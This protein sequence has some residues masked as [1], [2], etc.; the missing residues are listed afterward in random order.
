MRGQLFRPQ[1]LNI[2]GAINRMVLSAVC[3]FTRNT[4]VV[5]GFRRYQPRA[6]RRKADYGCRALV[7]GKMS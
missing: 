4:R 5:C 7:V 3:S 2:R 6:R 1:H